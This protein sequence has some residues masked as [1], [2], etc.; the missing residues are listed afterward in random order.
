MCNEGSDLSRAGARLTASRYLPFQARAHHGRVSLQA[1]ADAQGKA[2]ARQLNV[3]TAAVFPGCEDISRQHSF[4]VACSEAVPGERI[5]MFELQAEGPAE[6]QDWMTTIQVRQ[7]LQGASTQA[8]WM[9]LQ[10]TA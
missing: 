1:K 2:L 7:P 5:N 3:M 4:T 8:P 6:Q 9:G 10:Q